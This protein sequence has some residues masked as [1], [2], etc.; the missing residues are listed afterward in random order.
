MLFL[1][2]V[3]STLNHT[4]IVVKSF[5]AHGYATHFWGEE[6]AREL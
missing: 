3:Y 4:H 5:A 2:I 1:E 6:E